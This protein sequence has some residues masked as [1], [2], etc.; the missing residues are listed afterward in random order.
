[1]ANFIKVGERFLN[2][3]LVTD[4]QCDSEHDGQINVSL[5]MGAVVVLDGAEAVAILAWLD[6]GAIDVMEQYRKR[7][8]RSD[9]E[10]L[11]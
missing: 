8:E 2:L 3:D 5:A 9:P 11:A 6:L 1:M 10:R 7:A 4:V